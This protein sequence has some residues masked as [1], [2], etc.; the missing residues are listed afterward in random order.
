L[1]GRSIL[2]AAVSQQ[3]SLTAGAAETKRAAAESAESSWKENIAKK[4]ML[5]RCKEGRWKE[6]GGSERERETLWG[7]LLSVAAFY[8]RK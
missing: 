5:K 7:S 8:T 6:C 4:G 3:L 1:D 2:A